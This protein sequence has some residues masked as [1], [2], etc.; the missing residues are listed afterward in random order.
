L[1]E[2]GEQEHDTYP[3]PLLFKE[4]LGVVMIVRKLLFDESDDRVRGLE[5]FR[6]GDSKYLEA[7]VDEVVCPLVVVHDITG[8]VMSASVDLDDE[9]EFWT[10]EVDNVGTYSLLTTEL[11]A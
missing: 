3:V 7:V 2:T 9:F 10:V 4:G 1:D 5:N 8:L 6:V 11:V